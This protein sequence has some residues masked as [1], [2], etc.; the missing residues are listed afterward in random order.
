VIPLKKYTLPFLLLFLLIGCQS[1]TVSSDTL[2]SDAE[3]I[4]TIYKNSLDKGYLD[5]DEHKQVDEFQSKYIKNLKDYSSDKEL[6]S[7]MERLINSY[8]FYNVAIGLKNKDGEQMYKQ[9]FEDSI[10]KLD[11]QFNN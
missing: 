11:K 2:H 9:R 6:I 8:S 5:E 4:Y 1:Q 10:S 3:N 7:E